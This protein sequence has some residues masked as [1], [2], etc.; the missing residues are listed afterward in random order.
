MDKENR[1]FIF[2]SAKGQIIHSTISDGHIQMASDLFLLKK[3]DE[4][5]I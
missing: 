1:N 4:G 2:E 3:L 5:A